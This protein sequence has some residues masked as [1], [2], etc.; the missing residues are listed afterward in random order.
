MKEVLRVIRT[1]AC[2]ELRTR[3]KTAR[4]AATKIRGR[5][6]ARAI[7][8]SPPACN[9]RRVVLTTLPKKA[10]SLS[11]DGRY[12]S[13]RRKYVTRKRARRR[14]FHVCHPRSSRPKLWAYDG[15]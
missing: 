14:G 12:S 13:A 11:A 15:Q 5:V 7:M 8:G 9:A 4:N 10:I 1:S 3:P 6:L 2:A